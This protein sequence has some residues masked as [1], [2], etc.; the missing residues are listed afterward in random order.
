MTS[1][2]RRLLLPPIAAATLVL[3][4]AGTAF[5]GTPDATVS[6]FNEDDTPAGDAVC[7]F[8]FEFNPL[9]GGETGS[10]ELRDAGDAVVEHG[11]Y[12]VTASDGDREP[13]S[14]TFSL[15]NGTYTLVWD[16]E[17]P[18]DKSN[19]QLQIVV[20]CAA[21][22]TPSFEESVA[23]ET[24]KPTNKPGGGV[25]NVGGPTLPN[26]SAGG[27]VTAAPSPMAA[28]LLPALCGLLALIVVLP[29]RGIR[30]R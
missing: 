7:A 27:Q 3:G 21:N 17:T 22:P 28:L 23:A 26:T 16:S 5:A 13:D 18:I 30:R 9:P 12:S 1:L 4:V 20:S 24:S 14:G 15:D 8:Y 6:V 25:G 19:R 2:I 11:A 10:W 29:R